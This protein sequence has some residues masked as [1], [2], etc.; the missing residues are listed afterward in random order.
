MSLSDPNDIP[1]DKFL[2]L[3]KKSLISLLLINCK[4]S[5]RTAIKYWARI[6]FFPINKINQTMIVGMHMY[7]KVK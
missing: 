1:K 5:D 6:K 2:A 7:K 3:L 4:W